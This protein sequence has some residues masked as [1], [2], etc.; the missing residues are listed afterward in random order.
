[1][2]DGF[3]EKKKKR[4]KERKKNKKASGFCCKLNT[5]NSTEISAGFVLFSI[6][7]DPST[8]TL[9]C[10]TDVWGGDLWHTS[11][12]PHGYPQCCCREGSSGPSSSASRAPIFMT[13]ALIWT[14]G[15]AVELRLAA[16]SR[17]PPPAGWTPSA[18]QRGGDGQRHPWMKAEGCGSACAVPT[19]AISASC[20]AA[21]CS[22]SPSTSSTRTGACLTSAKCTL[23]RGGGSEA[24]RGRAGAGRSGRG[25]HSALRSSSHRSCCAWSCCRYRRVT[26]RSSGLARHRSLSRHLCEAKR[27]GSH[28]HRRGALPAPPSFSSLP[29]TCGE[30][31]R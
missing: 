13:T 16:P 4:E 20:A 28:P 2:L 19:C 9:C 27:R 29:H 8:F 12:R 5:N 10:S 25:A 22:K 1:M 6:G 18:A 23:R 31:R 14:R 21:S 7:T 17:S 15:A 11:Q 3:K 24:G 26:S 30:A